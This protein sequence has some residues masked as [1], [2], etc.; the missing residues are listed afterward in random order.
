MKTVFF[1]IVPAAFSLLVFAGCT[2][3]SEHKLPE[4]D[5]CRFVENL[6]AIDYSQADNWAIKPAKIEYPVDVFFVYP[7][8]IAD[9]YVL[10]MDWRVPEHNFRAKLIS[11]RDTAMFDGIANVYTPFYRQVSYPP[12]CTM[13]A[14]DD[15]ASSHYQLA[16]RDVVNAFQYYMAHEN[17]GRPIILMGHSQGSDLLIR[18]MK[19]FFSDPEYADKLVV[20]YLPGWHITQKEIDDNHLK[21][22]E[23]ADDIGVIAIWNTQTPEADKTV[24][25]IEGG[26]GINPLNWRRD[27]TPAGPDQQLGSAFYKKGTAEVETIRANEFG[28]VLRPETGGVAVNP[29][30]QELYSAGMPDAPVSLHGG[31]ISLFHNNIRANAQNRIQKYLQAHK[32][33]NSKPEPLGNVDQKKLDYGK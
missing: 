10:N 3:S 8:V 16:Y 25:S 12:V 28:A 23:S 11:G 26:L 17:E 31:D 1:K 21:F 27:A 33:F 24:F 30:N 13:L 2:T 20:A 14:E 5:H 19:E 29:P 15:F 7:T 22:A 9:H 6:S 32:N 18:L 4:G